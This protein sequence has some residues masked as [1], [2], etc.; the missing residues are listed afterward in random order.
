MLFG[1]SD[2]PKRN[3]GCQHSGV[4]RIGGIPA[5]GIRHT[6]Q[7]IPHG[8]RVHV[9]HTGSDFKRSSGLKERGNR[10]HGRVVLTLAKQ[11]GIDAINQFMPC[12]LIA[13]QC[14]FR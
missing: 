5:G 3:G 9:Q 2:S 14:T 11:I 4:A 10:K 1:V 8:V 6:L 7:A 13:E 12:I